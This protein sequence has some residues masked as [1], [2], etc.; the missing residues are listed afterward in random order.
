[1]G[2]KPASSISRFQV[3]ALTSLSGGLCHQSISEENSLFFKLFLIAIE[4][5]AK[6][7]EKYKLSLFW[8]VQCDI[9]IAF[10]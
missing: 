9:Q 2:S 5:L 6:T 7:L 3:P 10:I 8:G 1:M 4:T